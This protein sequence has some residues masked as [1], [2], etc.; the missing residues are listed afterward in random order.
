MVAIAK[1]T[2]KVGDLVVVQSRTWPGINKP[3]GVAKVTK[4]NVEN[5]TID[6]KYTLGGSEKNL[7]YVYVKLWDVDL[8]SSVVTTAGRREGRFSKPNEP[9]MQPQE[10]SSDAKRNA[11]E[12][13]EN[14]QAKLAEREKAN[15]IASKQTQED[16]AKKQKAAAVQQNELKSKKGRVTNPQ[17][18][19][20]ENQEFHQKTINFNETAIQ[21]TDVM[22][23]KP[24][25]ASNSTA[26]VLSGTLN[27]KPG[28]RVQTLNIS[29]V[30]PVELETFITL[31]SRV[32]NGAEDVQLDTLLLQIKSAHGKS[33]SEEEVVKYLKVMEERNIAMFVP[34]TRTLYRI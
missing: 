26:G 2:Y 6:V 20:K 31:T 30:N 17:C 25:A 3:G 9:S 16:A 4:V 8:S 18:V 29:P 33:I 32:M 5:E 21:H 10:K 22:K 12:G 13:Q 23:K 28:S 15:E 24:V 1:I 14:V 34:T 7:E 11:N 19:G 27:K